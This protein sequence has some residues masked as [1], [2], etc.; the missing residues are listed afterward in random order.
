MATIK[1]DLV[2]QP[3]TGG[4]RDVMMVIAVNADGTPISGGGGVAATW[5]TLEGKPDY[6][7]AGNTQADARTAIGAGTSNL[8]IGTTATTAMAGNTPIPAAAT[9]ATLSG[10]PAV[11]AAGSDAAAAR[12]AIGAGTSSL[13]L[14]QSQAGIATKPAIAALTAESTLEEV[15]AALQA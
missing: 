15:I 5:D 7:A 13:T 3:A 9:W 12:T 1:T 6:I 2:Q 10:K 14:A 11:I 8:T 4:A